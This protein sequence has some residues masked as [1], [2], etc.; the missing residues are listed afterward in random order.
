MIGESVWRIT[1]IMG[2]SYSKR[3][4]CFF[5]CLFI[6]KIIKPDKYLQK[7]TGSFS[8]FDNYFSVFFLKEF[9]VSI[10]TIC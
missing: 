7:N 1:K 5:I 3:N 6:N 8:Q 4:I 10:E 2:K 9:I